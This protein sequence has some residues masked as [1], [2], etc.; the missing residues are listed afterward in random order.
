VGAH[1]EFG[2]AERRALQKKGAPSET[3]R[4]P[5]CKRLLPLAGASDNIRPARKE[6]V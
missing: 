1:K 4:S 6:S 3:L 5:A 2:Q